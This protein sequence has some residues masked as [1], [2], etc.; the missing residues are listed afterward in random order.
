[1]KNNKA[2]VSTDT[3]ILLWILVFQAFIVLGIGFLHVTPTTKTVGGDINIVGIP[4]ISFTQTL[5]TNISYLGWGNLLLFA[6]LE[7]CLI[8]IIAKLIRG[9][10]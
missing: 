6:P 3:P 8:Y 4:N 1:M 5:V 10:G 9:G 2:Q 7:I